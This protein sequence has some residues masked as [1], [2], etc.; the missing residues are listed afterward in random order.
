MPCRIA[1][2][3]ARQILTAA[4]PLSEE[5]RDALAKIDS[6]RMHLADV[7]GVGVTNWNPNYPVGGMQSVPQM[8]HPRGGNRQRL[9]AGRAFHTELQHGLTTRQPFGAGGLQRRQLDPGRGHL[10]R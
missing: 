5:L 1:D 7:F 8:D 2:S 6:A 4:D 10:R 9:R 3:A